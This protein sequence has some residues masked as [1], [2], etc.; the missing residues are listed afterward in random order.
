MTKQFETIYHPLSAVKENLHF[1]HGVY[2]NKNRATLLL[3]AVF[4]PKI[5]DHIY[6]GVFAECIENED[7]FSRRKGRDITT[8]R[9]FRLFSVPK[10]PKRIM[11]PRNT[12]C[13]K[14]GNHMPIKLHKILQKFEHKSSIDILDEVIA[15][16]CTVDILDWTELNP[17]T[18]LSNH[19]DLILVDNVVNIPEED[20]D[21]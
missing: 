11:V 12:F 2:R 10:K 17:N 15:G 7:N 21:A 13:W 8:D 19:M 20:H 14:A 6:F 9:L 16:T 1:Y 18:I 5:D 3:S 4:D